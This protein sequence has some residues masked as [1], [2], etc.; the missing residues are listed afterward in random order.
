L[1]VILVIIGP[2]WII[3]WPPALFRGPLGTIRF[4]SGVIGLH[5]GLLLFPSLIFLIGIVIRQTRVIERVKLMILIGLCA[6]VAWGNT[7]E[8]IRFWWPDRFQEF[9]SPRAPTETHLR[10]WSPDSR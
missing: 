6:A 10:Q 9:D 8:M 2:I 3:P 7:Q 4:I 1:L 5:F